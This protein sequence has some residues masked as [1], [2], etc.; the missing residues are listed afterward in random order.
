MI[1]ASEHDTT[2]QH[3]LLVA[4]RRMAGQDVAAITRILE[5]FLLD[6]AQADRAQL[7]IHDPEGGFAWS[8]LD[9]EREVRVGG[10]VGEGLIG[11]ALVS[12]EA[13]CVARVDRDARFRVT[14]D[15]EGSGQAS[16]IAQPIVWH[17]P[18]ASESLGVLIVGRDPDR[19]RGPL[20][21][22]EAE[23]VATLAHHV[24][25]T[26]A[27]LARRVELEQALE[28]ET[29]DETHADLRPGIY[30]SEAVEAHAWTA[31]GE[32]ARLHS[33]AMAWATRALVILVAIAF[34]YLALVD[35][36][37]YASGPALVRLGGRSEVTARERGS[38]VEVL[39]EPGD[40]VM[41]D[42]P[43]VRFHDVE[44]AAELGRIEQEFALQLRNMLRDPGDEAAQQSVASLRAQRQRALAHR[45]EHLVR[46]PMAGRVRDVRVRPGQALDSGDV[47]VSLD[48]EAS[49]PQVIAVLPGDERP[50][51]EPGMPLSF[52]IEGYPDAATTLI[53]ERV[54]DDVVGP[55]E[56]LRLLGPEVAEGLDIQGSVIL[57]HAR[58]P[59]EAFESKRGRYR[60][61]DG[62]RGHAEVRVRST[63]ILEAL[64]PGLE[65]L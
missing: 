63:T 37:Q 15:P 39:V 38:V 50:R 9:D 36:G 29:H 11:Q 43:L 62:M 24:G 42:Q 28:L 47:L 33:R 21:E 18:M 31:R 6:Q 65:E 26:L 3:A 45:Q 2:W 35:I 57:V 49:E 17:G 14:D 25:P 55:A 23:L 59:G 40:A 51:I 20:G 27:A 22:R 7:L 60:W 8:A 13:L 53:V 58:L 34:A 1:P 30:R 54:H 56:A 61:H 41:V 44:D 4:L 46:A 32:V 19:A 52:E 10:G 64:V 16:L 12:G 48:G 5:E